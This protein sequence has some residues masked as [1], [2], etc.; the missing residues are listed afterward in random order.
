MNRY[1]L[2]LSFSRII[3]EIT[4]V[5]ED[6]LVVVYGGD[7]PHIGSVVLSVPRLSLRNDG[8]I[9]AT[10]SVINVTGHKDE[11]I[12]R[13]IAEMI[14]SEYNCIVTCTG[15]FHVDDITEEQLKEI[16]EKLRKFNFQHTV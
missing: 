1:E 3:V 15:G 12:C 5:G 8:S 13:T 14:A 11:V 7:K 16:G 9:S 2:E 4:D 10:S 6:K